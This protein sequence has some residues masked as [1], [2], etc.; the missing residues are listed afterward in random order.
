MVLR[1]F[2]F[3]PQTLEH[4]SHLDCLSW[5]AQ[6]SNCP[7]P[8][9]PCP[10]SPVNE[11]LSL[12]CFHRTNCG[13]STSMCCSDHL[14]SSWNPGSLPGRSSSLDR[15]LA[16]RFS[17]PE[18]FNRVDVRRR[19]G[20]PTNALQESFLELNWMF[21][22]HLKLM[23]MNVNGM[24]VTIQ[25]SIWSTDKCLDQHPCHLTFQE[26]EQFVV[27][28]RW[29][30]LVLNDFCFQIQP[31]AENVKTEVEV[32]PTFLHC[33]PSFW[34][35]QVLWKSHEDLSVLICLL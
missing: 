22:L 7:G 27:H 1:G 33:N 16:S 2:P 19:C 20:N 29:R 18:K 26:Q 24:S 6:R 5:T 31:L 34:L 10:S 13:W 8:H 11:A 12:Q 17:A 4:K 14:G 30:P 21:C 35:I 3:S 23:S 28:E 9:W 32:G 25:L 15:M